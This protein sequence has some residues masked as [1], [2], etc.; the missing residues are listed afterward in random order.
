[1]DEQS[2]TTEGRNLLAFAVLVAAAGGLALLRRFSSRRDYYKEYEQACGSKRW[3]E[4][5]NTKLAAVEAAQKGD[6][7][8]AEAVAKMW[9]HGDNYNPPDPKEA[10]RW[11]AKAAQLRGMGPPTSDPPPSQPEPEPTRTGAEKGF[12]DN[13]EAKKLWWTNAWINWNRRQWY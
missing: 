4:A 7:E 10:E 1:M 11:I 3:W 12:W 8:A 6:A 5:T 2:K 9:L 13:A